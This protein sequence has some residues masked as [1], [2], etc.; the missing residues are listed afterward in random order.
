MKESFKPYCKL[1]SVAASTEVT[2][3]FLDSSGGTLAC[4]YARVEPVSGGSTTDWFL[5]TPEPFAAADSSKFD[6]V[7]MENVTLSGVAGSVSS[8]NTGSIVISTNNTTTSLRIS[9][10]SSSN[11]YF[12]V[13]YGIVVAASTGKYNLA[14]KG[15]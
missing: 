5:V 2:V 4:N 14:D 12:A 7:S 11:M 8:A 3:N 1:V 9:H 13:T 15:E 6:A 10:S